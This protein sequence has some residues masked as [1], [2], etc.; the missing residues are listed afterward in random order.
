MLIALLGTLCGIS[1]AKDT[2][3]LQVYFLAGQ[4]IMQGQSPFCGCGY[5][6]SW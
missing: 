4:S 2:Q 3:P 5:P 6:I 1:L